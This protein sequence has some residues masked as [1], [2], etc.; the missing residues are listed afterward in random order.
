MEKGIFLERWDPTH[1]DTC[2]VVEF[3]PERGFAKTEE[4]WPFLSN[5]LD[6]ELHSTFLTSSLRHSRTH[7]NDW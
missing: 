6:Y 2:R 3:V 4:T 7:S 5:G 1:F